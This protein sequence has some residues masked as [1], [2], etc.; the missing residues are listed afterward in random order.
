MITADQIKQLRDATGIS[1]MQCKKALED[2][3]GDTDKALVFLKKKGIEVAA[4]KSDRTLNAGVVEAYIHPGG[5]VGA[6]V[7][8][9]CETD[10]VSRNEEFKAL[11]K[12]LVMH[13]AASAPIYLDDTSIL[14]SVLQATKDT[15]TKEVSEL[16]KPEEMKSKILEGKVAAYLSERTLLKQPFVKNPDETVSDLLKNKIQKFGEKIEIRRFARFSL[17]DK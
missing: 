10:F 2:A 9:N 13:I 14:A 15:F 6:M 1:V 11:A 7:E 5:A 12:D 16:D 17:L 3:G 8:L 4:K